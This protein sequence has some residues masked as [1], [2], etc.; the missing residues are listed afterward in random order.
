MADDFPPGSVWL[1]GAGPGDVELLTLK[2]ARLIA[3]AEIVF[4][5]ALVGP[6]ILALAAHAE[7]IPVGKR[8]GRH[9][10]DQD[11]INGLLVEAALRGKRVVR[12]KGGDPAIFARSA[13]EM[14]AC[15]RAG[16]VARICPGITTA[17]AAAASASLS[18]SLRGL[19]RRVQFVTAHARAGE[20]LDL[21]WPAL[22]HAG[23]TLA[24]YMGRGATREIS[25]QLTAAGLPGSTPVLV[26]C[27]VSLPTEQHLSTRLDLLPLAVKSIAGN[28]PTLLLIGEA[29]ARPTAVHAAPARAL[30]A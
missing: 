2:A 25:E 22:A 5:D 9:S 14:E 28:R 21:D 29:V 19:A 18:L 13:E 16:I 20:A 24:F 27:D 1:V 15:A 30:T 7:L 26:A 23:S 11:A 6:E 4:Y 17:S 8:A 10:K 12:L 3:T